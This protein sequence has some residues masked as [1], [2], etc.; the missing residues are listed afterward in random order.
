M[1]P[2]QFSETRFNWH[3]DTL[4][5]VAKKKKRREKV[6]EKVA[7]KVAVSTDCVCV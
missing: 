2:K 5:L 1:D 4:I 6:T 7:V 3:S